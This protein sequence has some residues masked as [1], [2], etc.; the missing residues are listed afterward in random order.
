MK[1]W[2]NYKPDCNVPYNSLESE[3]EIDFQTS[4]DDAMDMIP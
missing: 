4:S 3:E 2:L 1:E